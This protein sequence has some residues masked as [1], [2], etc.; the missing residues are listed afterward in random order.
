MRYFFGPNRNDND[1]N[2]SSESPTNADGNIPR[3]S[4]SMPQQPSG[5]VLQKVNFFYKHWKK[6]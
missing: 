1:G 3:N 6:R 4:P 2:D 5:L